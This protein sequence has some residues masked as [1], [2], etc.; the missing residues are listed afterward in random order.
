MKSLAIFPRVVDPAKEQEFEVDTG[1]WKDLNLSRLTCYHLIGDKR[2]RWFGRSKNGG[3]NRIKMP[4]AYIVTADK[5][6]IFMVNATLP[7]MI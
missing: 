5:G 3:P 4:D 7:R 2:A 6:D 1:T